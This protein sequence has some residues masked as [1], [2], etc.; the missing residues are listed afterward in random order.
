MA[1]PTSESMRN[2]SLEVWGPSTRSTNGLTDFDL[3]LPVE[4]ERFQALHLASNTCWLGEFEV[5]IPIEKQ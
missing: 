5:N 2:Y 4:K 1:K 3:T